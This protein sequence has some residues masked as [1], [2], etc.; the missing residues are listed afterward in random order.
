MEALE[1]YL[2]AHCIYSLRA[3]AVP[4]G[5]DVV[6]HFVLRSR[7]GACDQFASALVIMCRLADIPARVATG[8]ATGREEQEADGTYTVRAKDAHAWAEVFFPGIG[9]VP[10]N[11]EPAGQEGEL[12]WLELLLTAHWDIAAREAAR[13]AGWSAVALILLTLALSAVLDPATLLQRF[14][15]SPRRSA[16]AELAR[17]YQD[18]YG[19]ALRRRGIAHGSVLTPQE[20]TSLLATELTEP[21]DREALQ[22]LNE[23]FYAQRYGQSVDEGQVHRLRQDLRALRKVLLRRPGR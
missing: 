6:A 13:V 4:Y 17:D 5:Q 16:L 20:A 19:R 23:S 11:P 12:S 9:W 10:F 21:A 1:S 2:E 18:L 15:R 22:R 3:P 8:Y 7:R 14:R